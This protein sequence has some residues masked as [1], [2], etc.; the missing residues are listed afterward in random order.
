[1]KV[2]VLRLGHR[3]GR[4]PRISTHCALAARALGASEIIYSGENDEKMIDGINKTAQRWGGKFCA[5]YDLEWKKCILSYK[6]KGYFVVHLTMYGIQ[7]GS[8]MMKIR[9]QKKILLVVGGEKVHPEVYH[10]ADKNIAVTNQPHSEVAAL[11]VFLHECFL[12]KEHKF[13]KARLR[14]VPQEKGKKVL[15]KESSSLKKHNS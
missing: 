2:S 12:G 10:L 7:A 1:M 4:D 8:V 5:R 14:I 13:S 15:N 9:K 6:K 11:A 3:I